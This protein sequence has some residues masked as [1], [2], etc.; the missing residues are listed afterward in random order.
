MIGN[1]L[2]RRYAVSTLR[3]RHLWVS[4][5]IY[6]IGLVLIGML[7]AL[8]LMYGTGYGGD[9]RLCVRSVYGQL[10][11]IQFLLLWVWGGYNAG[12]ALREEML[13]KSYDF[14]RLLPLSSWQ[15][16]IGIV[17]GRNLLALA[18]AAVTA[19]VQLVLGLAGGVPF[20]LQAQV[21][22]VLAAT[23]AMIWCVAVLSS[24]RPHRGKEQRGGSALLLIFLA[25]GVIPFV[26]QLVAQV[27]AVAK[28]DGW[29]VP[30]FAV[31]LPGVLLVGAIA[32]YLAGWAAFGAMRRLRQAEWTIFSRKGAY[33]FLAGCLVILLG[34]FWKALTKGDYAIW[35]WYAASTH[36]LF[37]LIPFG[38]MRTSEQYMELTYDLGSRRDGRKGIEWMFLAEANPSTWGG[39]YALWTVFAVSGAAIQSFNLVLWALVLAAC[40]FFAWSVLLLL[41][42]LGVVGAPRNEKLKFFAGFLAMLY[43]I[44]PPLLAA[45]LDQGA[46]Y[47]FSYFGIWTA[48]WTR[49]SGGDAGEM[50]LVLPLLVNIMIAVVLAAIIRHRYQ[51][52]M[53]A[54]CSML[55]GS[56]VASR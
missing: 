36:I 10:L 1:P 49:A 12:N 25:L 44:L 53:N 34:L 15:K 14:F 51:G 2:V 29:T 13:R 22:F 3:P 16:L 5:G 30:F 7:N 50:V 40:V 24:V 8:A 6:T 46:V 31:D 52:L 18:L 33:R 45:V 54:R 43:L 21:V 17:I 28:L 56:D 9:T 26:M 41:T 39:L 27:S 20:L 48:V 32:A 38:H 11:A 37:A 55:E 47:S 19:A 4:A 42:E 35:F 23:T